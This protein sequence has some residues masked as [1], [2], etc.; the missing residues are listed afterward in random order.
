ME[1][2]TK[3]DHSMSVLTHRRFYYTSLLRFAI[4]AVPEHTGPNRKSQVILLFQ[5]VCTIHL[6]YLLFSKCFIHVFLFF[7]GF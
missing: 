4:K 3:H 7:F 2:L 5:V 1:G 6:H